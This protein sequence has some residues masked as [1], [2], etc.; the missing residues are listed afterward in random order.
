MRYRVELIDGAARDQA[1]IHIEKKA[2]DSAAAHWYNGLEA[3]VDSLETYP[4]RNPVALKASNSASP[5]GHVLHRKK[6]HAYCV[7][8]QIHEPT[9]SSAYSP[10][11]TEP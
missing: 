11:A 5:L 1:R 6:P 7:I 2:A 8:Y 4:N 10:S 3:A 9:N